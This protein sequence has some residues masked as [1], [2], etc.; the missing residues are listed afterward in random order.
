M[1]KNVLTKDLLKGTLLD[2]DVGNNTIPSR[3]VKVK[4]IRREGGW[5]PPEHEAAV[6]LSDS[7]RIYCVP[8]REST[9]Q[10]V[11]CLEGLGKGQKDNL[12]KEMGLEDGNSF[13]I[14]LKGQDNFW[15]HFEVSLGRNGDT[16]DLGSPVEFLKWCVLRSDTEHIAPTWADREQRGT[17]EFALIEENEVSMGKIN[18]ADKMKEAYRLL[19]RLDTSE[20]KMRDFLFLYYLDYKDAQKP[21]KQASP[22]WLKEQI[23]DIVENNIDRFLALAEDTQ[24][25]TKLLI[26]R[27]VDADVITVENKKYSV[28]DVE[29]PF[30]GLTKLIEYLDDDRN[31]EER[32]RIMALTDKGEE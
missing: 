15:R 17:Y 1:E 19:G 29:E 7:K 26:K 21:P 22:Q 13:N 23:V 4:I 11:N 27:A 32:I 9:G 25:E 5:L 2:P 8:G 24:Y 16:F 28:P 14:N 3:K 30:G 12:A 18:K 31:Q 6:M 10:L 20:S